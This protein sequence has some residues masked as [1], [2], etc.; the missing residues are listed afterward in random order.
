LPESFTITFQ[1]GDEVDKI[2]WN[3]KDGFENLD[4]VVATE[5][6]LDRWVP[7]II[8]SSDQIEPILEEFLMDVLKEIQTQAT[9]D[10]TDFLGHI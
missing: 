6:E 8:V 1:G 3:I 10:E 9:T 4:N 5:D 2:I 7:E